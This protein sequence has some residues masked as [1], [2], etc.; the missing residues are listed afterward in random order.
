MATKP[1]NSVLIAIL[2]TALC[3][4]GT[5]VQAADVTAIRTGHHAN[6]TRVVLDLTGPP[7]YRVEYT[8]QQNLVIISLRDAALR[9]SLSS[10]ELAGTPLSLV[11]GEHDAGGNL[12]ISLR[13]EKPVSLRHAAYGADDQYGERLVLDL[14][15]PG[16][17][18][19]EK[20]A[21]ATSRVAGS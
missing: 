2:G 8:E 6:F 19:T 18:S 4:A 10:L 14:F 9:A 3:G 11:M 7:D 16:A 12:R 1:L 15:D 20:H 21:A 13:L 17:S 5:E